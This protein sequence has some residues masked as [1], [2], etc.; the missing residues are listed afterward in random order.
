MP[1]DD[2]V[3]ALVARGV[4]PPGTAAPERKEA[5]YGLCS[6]WLCTRLKVGETLLARVRPSAFQLVKEDVPLIMVGAGAGVAPFR[7]FWSE[8]GASAPRTA[9]AALFFGC[10]HPDKDWIYRLEMS[11]ACSA[12][13]QAKA[14]EPRRPLT[15][16]FTAFSRIGE[17]GVYDPSG[18]CGEYVQDQ[19]RAQAAELREWMAEG[20]VV[21]IC[22]SNRMGHGVLGALG[23]V[24]AGG[25]EEVQRLRREGRIVQENWGEPATPMELA[26]AGGKGVGAAMGESA[27]ELEAK[28]AKAL[29]EAVKNGNHPEVD[30]LIAEGANVNFQAPAGCREG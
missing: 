3:A 27:E 5:W 16:L 26:A 28:L 23:E 7:A 8:L 1:L 14:D 12:S 19:L 15:A 17:E 24:L 4:L 13:G 18:N 29:L 25:E 30:R 6:Q 21:Y 10:Q 2:A 20:G 11:G 22:G 9:P